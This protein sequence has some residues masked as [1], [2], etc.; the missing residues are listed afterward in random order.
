MHLFYAHAKLLQ[1]KYSLSP[2]IDAS[3]GGIP[4]RFGNNGIQRSDAQ[5]MIP[6]GIGGD[7]PELARFKS[8]AHSV[9]H[10]KSRSDVRW[11]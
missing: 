11:N 2:T 9:E 4:F 5:T 6:S 1:E 3:K 7:T 10:S 8:P